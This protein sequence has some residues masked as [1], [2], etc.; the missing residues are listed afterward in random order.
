MTNI[1]NLL[2]LQAWK[3]CIRCK[4]ILN[5]REQSN[6]KWKENARP[7]QVTV[8]EQQ[9]A[10]VPGNMSVLYMIMVEGMEIMVMKFQLLSATHFP[11]APMA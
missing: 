2:V 3:W 8:S 10:Q 7:H 4:Y 5:V 11:Q 1:N 9:N 6:H